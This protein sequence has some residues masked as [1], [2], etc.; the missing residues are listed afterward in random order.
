MLLLSWRLQ[1]FNHIGTYNY[2]GYGYE[3]DMKNCGDYPIFCR[4]VA[5]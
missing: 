4:S 5:S 2:R 1:Y 3:Y